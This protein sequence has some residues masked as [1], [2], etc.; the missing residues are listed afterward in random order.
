MA[1]LKINVYTNMDN[2]KEESIFN[3]IIVN[4]VIKYI[5]S[6]N[7]KFSVLLEDNLLIKENDEYVI[8]IDFIKEIISIFM[9][10]YNKEF[11]KDIKTLILKKEKNV[12]YV[13]YNLTDENVLNEYEIKF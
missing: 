2:H 9:K 10:E 1:K 13:K 5:D 4:D 12:F 8:K 7:N 11:F 6:D 3:A